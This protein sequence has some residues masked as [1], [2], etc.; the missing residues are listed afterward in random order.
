MNLWLDRR[1]CLLLTHAGTLFPVFVADV[2][3]ADLR[4]LGSYIVGHIAAELASEGLRPDSLGQLDP[5]VHPGGEDG[6]PRRPRLHE[7]DGL[8]R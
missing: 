1:K 4:A 2:R 6:E 5:D 3:A 8:W 7:R